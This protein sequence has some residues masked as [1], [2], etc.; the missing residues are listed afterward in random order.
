MIN[1]KQKV[2]IITFKMQIIMQTES[3]EIKFSEIIKMIEIEVMHFEQEQFLK[4]D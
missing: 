4:A 2:L 1:E 3:L